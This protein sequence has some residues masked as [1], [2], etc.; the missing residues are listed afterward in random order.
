M[1]DTC[2]IIEEFNSNKKRKS[3]IPFDNL[4]AGM[5]SNKKLNPSVTQLFIRHTKVNISLAFVT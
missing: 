2:K 1:D 3:L 4:V 5:L